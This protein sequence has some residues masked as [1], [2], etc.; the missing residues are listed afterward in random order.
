MKP[1]KDTLMTLIASEDG[2]TAVEYGL[3][4]ALVTIGIVTAVSVLSETLVDTWEVMG[5]MFVD[6]GIVD[7]G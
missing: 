6:H 4:L 7:G 3:T 2:V 5:D 1:L